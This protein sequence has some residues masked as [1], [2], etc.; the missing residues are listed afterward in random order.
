MCIYYYFKIFQIYS[1]LMLVDI[2]SL[3][4]RSQK[5]SPLKTLVISFLGQA[6]YVQ[7]VDVDFEGCRAAGQPRNSQG[8]FLSS[9]PYRARPLLTGLLRQRAAVPHKHLRDQSL[10]W[11]PVLALTLRRLQCVK[12]LVFLI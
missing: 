8:H 9:T 7:F 4:K 5:I 3:L 11:R 1:A 10:C 12:K 6:I 2:I